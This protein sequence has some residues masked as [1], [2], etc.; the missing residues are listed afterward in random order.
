MYNFFRIFRE[1][2]QY[3]YIVCSSISLLLL[4]GEFSCY[5]CFWRIFLVHLQFFLLCVEWFDLLFCNLVTPV[6]FF[7]ALLPCQVFSQFVW[8]L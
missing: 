2:S 5:S 3:F 1:I 6:S 7:D 4:L 8:L